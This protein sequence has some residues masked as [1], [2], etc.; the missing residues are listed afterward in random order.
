MPFAAAASRLA[1]MAKSGGK[2]NSGRADLVDAVESGSA[3]PRALDSALLPEP[4]RELSPEQREAMRKRFGGGG[5]GE[6]G[7]RGGGGERGGR[8]GRGGGN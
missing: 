6:R 7:G 2:V 1:F 4:M 8:R 3:D 5:G